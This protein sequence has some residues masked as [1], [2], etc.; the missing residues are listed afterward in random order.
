MP[1]AK[2]KA[3][4][5]VTA[6]AESKHAISM[7]GDDEDKFSPQL[8]FLRLLLVRTFS[9]L[10]DINSEWSAAIMNLNKI[11][12][13]APIASILCSKEYGTVDG[14]SFKIDGDDEGVET[15]KSIIVLFDHPGYLDTDDN[16]PR[17]VTKLIGMVGA[18]ELASTVMRRLLGHN[19]GY[20]TTKL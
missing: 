4:D 15:A 16:T 11:T 19:R 7:D 10:D 20:C 17:Q 18:M 1:I 14:G 13:K 2:A 12:T 6:K 8:P 5:L 3:A 9:I